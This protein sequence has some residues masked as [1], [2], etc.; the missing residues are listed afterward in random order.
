MGRNRIRR[1]MT[2][3]CKKMG[4]RILKIS[5]LRKTYNYVRKNGLRSAYYAALERIINEKGS[6][7]HYK[8]PGKDVLAAQRAAGHKFSCRF[9]IL[10]PAYETEEEY[11]REMMDS[12]LGQS[13]GNLELLIADASRSGRVKE[14][15][16]T[17]QD[18]RIRYIPLPENKGISENTNYALEA[19]K[20]DY[21]GLLDHDDVL[22]GDALYS[23]AKAIYQREKNGDTAW[24]LYSDEDKGN[25]G[26]T[27]FYEPH[28]KPP[29]NMDLLLSNNYVCHFLVMKRELMQELRF[30]GEYDGAQDYD[31]ILRAV[32]RLAYG[33][34][35]NRHGGNLHGDTGR[36]A[37]RGAENAPQD[38][39]GDREGRGE[40]ERES[41]GAGSMAGRSAVIH[42]PKVLYHWRCHDLS[43]AENPASKRYAYEAGKRALEDFLKERGWKGTVS[44]TEHLGFY[45]IAY[46]ENIFAQRVDVGVEAGRILDRRGRICGGAYNENGSVLYMG[47]HREFGGYMHRACLRQEVYAADIRCMRVREELWGIFAQV[48]GVPY[49]ENGK[50]WFDYAG[51]ERQGGDIS[52]EQVQ[53]C[54]DFGRRVR[55]AG[56]T[57]VWSP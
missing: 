34:A 11:F 36:L 20:G 43:T 29:L 56:Y 26:L 13:Y 14:I 42:I 27:E 40:E 35:E 54:L 52:A 41:A 49:R 2:G 38:L 22:T 17:Y 16:D 25:S 46:K 37:Y 55:E 24:L 50:G 3:E 4:R 33:G 12:V 9:S 53:K 23:M 48:F 45:H 44:H 30:R 6:S 8:Q 51:T 19:A 39:C 7:Y 47:L 28:F 18:D 5:N 10:V 15:V 1:G 57:V 31:L 32:G 21:I